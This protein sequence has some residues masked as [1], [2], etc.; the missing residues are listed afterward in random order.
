MSEAG[1]QVE[2]LKKIKFFEDHIE[3]KNRKINFEQ[4]KSIKF[5]SVATK[6]S[7]NFIPTGTTYESDLYLILKDDKRIQIK[8]ESSFFKG[9][10]Q[11]DH[12]EAIWKASEIISIATFNSRVDR[13]EK[14]FDKKIGDYIEKCE[15]KNI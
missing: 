8:Q 4:I 5:T 10:S 13:Y 14:E 6:H 2:G 3:Y 1:Q 15:T 7:I 12:S 9:I 11:K